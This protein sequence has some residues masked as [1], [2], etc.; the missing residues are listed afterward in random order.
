MFVEVQGRRLSAI[1]ATVLKVR[2]QFTDFL[3]GVPNI[4]PL[5][6]DPKRVSLCPFFGEKRQFEGEADLP[7]PMP[8]G[9]TKDRQKNFISTSGFSLVLPDVGNL[10]KN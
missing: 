4:D 8:S 3:V 5:E 10:T 1:S 6:S 9:T 2:E 7:R